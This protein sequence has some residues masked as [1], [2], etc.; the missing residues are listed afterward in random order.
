MSQKHLFTDYLTDNDPGFPLPQ[1]EH[2]PLQPQSRAFSFSALVH[3]LQRLGPIFPLSLLLAKRKLRITAGYTK[4]GEV[5]SDSSRMP[6]REN[7]KALPE[8]VWLYWLIRRSLAVNVGV[9]ARRV[10]LEMIP[11]CLIVLFAGLLGLYTQ[12]VKVGS[13]A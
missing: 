7:E 12:A 8:P 13:K 9:L 3:F 6:K 10:S 1:Q 11:V 4:G 2:L 5:A